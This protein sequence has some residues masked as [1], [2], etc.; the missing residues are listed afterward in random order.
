MQRRELGREGRCNGSSFS[1][2]LLFSSVCADEPIEVFLVTHSHDDVGWLV[3]WEDYYTSEV[4]SILNTVM[5]ALKDHP[6]RKYNQVEVAFFRR[7]WSE[8]TPSQKA[9]AKKIIS[10]GQIEFNIGGIAMNDEACPTYYEEINQMTDGADWLFQNFGVKPK[11]N[12]H[13]DPFGHSAA[14]ASLWAQMGFS[15]WGLN[16]IPYTIKNDMKSKKGLEFVWRGSSTLGSQSQIF[17][18]VMDSHYSTPGEMNLP[19]DGNFDVAKRAQDTIAMLKMRSTW[20]KHKK[21]LIPFGDDFTHQQA[22]QDYNNMDRLINYINANTSSNG[23]KIKYAFLSEY[24]QAVHDLNI[25]WDVFTGDFFP[26]NDSPSAFWSGYYSSRPWFK[27]YLRQCDALLASAEILLLQAKY[28]KNDFANA[29][30]QIDHLRMATARAT[31]HDAVSGTEKVPTQTDY[32]QSLDNGVAATKQVL[33]GILSKFSSS[34]SIEKVKASRSRYAVQ[35][36]LAWNRNQVVSVISYSKNAVVLDSKGN[37]V[38]SQM[39]PVPSYS[40]VGAPYRLYFQVNLAPLS[41]SFFTINWTNAT[42]DPNVKISSSPSSVSNNYISLTF[43]SQ[44]LKLNSVSN[45]RDQ[46]KVTANL[47]YIQYYSGLRF[48]GQPSGNYIFRPITDSLSNVGSSSSQRKT[49]DIPLSGTYSNNPFVFP[50]A[51]TDSGSLDSTLVNVNQ[52]TNSKVFRAAISRLDLNT[53]WGD[54][55]E[56]DFAVFDDFALRN[57]FPNVNYAVGRTFIPSNGKPVRIQFNTASHSRGSFSKAPVVILSVQSTSVRYIA[58]SLSSVDTSGFSADLKGTD[59]DSWN[60]NDGVYL[61]WFAVD[62]GNVQTVGQEYL[63]SGVVSLNANP[64]GNAFS[65]RISHMDACREGLVLATV[66]SGTSNKGYVFAV[67]LNYRDATSFGAVIRKIGN[68]Q[69]W[70][71]GVSIHYVVLP[72]LAITEQIAS[73]VNSVLVDGPLVK[74]VQQTYAQDYGQTFLLYNNGDATT[75]SHVEIISEVGPLNV[76]GRELVTRLST[77]LNTQ[78]VLYTDDNGLEIMKRTFDRKAQE[79]QAGNLFPMVQRAYLRD[80]SQSTQLVL[81]SDSTHAVGSFANGQVEVMLHRRTKDDDGRGEADPMNDLTPIRPSLLLTLSGNDQGSVASRYLSLLQNFPPQLIEVS[82]DGKDY[83]SKVN[84][85]PPNVNLLTYRTFRGGKL[86]RLQHIYAKGEHSQLSKPATVDLSLLFPNSTISSLTE[87]NLNANTPYSQMI[88]E[89]L[90]W[91]TKV[92]PNPQVP[93]P[94]NG[95][96]LTIQPME[97]RTFIAN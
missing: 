89:R 97:I 50:I 37:K 49:S 18:H 2:S 57:T 6:E 28:A 83:N 90:V 59:S 66:Q 16:R 91:K 65:Q 68:D 46:K 93:I 3:P 85:L 11:A 42:T 1:S 60:S 39:N 72:R 76:Q 40:K 25:D 54:N 52:Q 23:I 45:V 30:A 20:Y 44:S 4:R 48:M 32:I 84:S 43:D 26:Y 64:N 67:N 88:K 82:F 34:P 70:N 10:R 14:T 17:A 78:G 41:T 35:N 5:E 80:E 86:I 56:V 75:S 55:V 92:G 81:L 69:K 61:N 94:I 71:A 77:N 58:A 51:Y 15:S 36:P 47:D 79:L 21:L 87:M 22:V 95:N 7:W 31:H 38:Q 19:V 27:R 9:I 33:S 63:R 8:I 96:I 74:E 62:S 53:G 12:W 73:K 13:I 24:I 29:D